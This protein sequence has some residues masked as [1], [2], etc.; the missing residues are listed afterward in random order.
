MLAVEKNE[1][2]KKGFCRYQNGG[3]MVEAPIKLLGVTKNWAWF[4]EFDIFVHNGVE[5]VVEANHTTKCIEIT[6]LGGR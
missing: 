4:D 3:Y 1:V 6:R 5:Y 2:K